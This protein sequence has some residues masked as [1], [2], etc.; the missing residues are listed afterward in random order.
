MHY[1]LCIISAKLYT[2]VER[3]RAGKKNKKK[4]VL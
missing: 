3:G 4:K 1:A 2:Y